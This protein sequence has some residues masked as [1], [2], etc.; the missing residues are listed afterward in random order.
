MESGEEKTEEMKEIRIRVPLSD[1]ERGQRVCR[2]RFM[3]DFLKTAYY[4]RINR[5][6][7]KSKEAR[8]RTLLRDKELVL[9]LIKECLEELNL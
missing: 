9:P 2:E 3:S 4:E 7:S 6:E 8:L 1:Y 5:I